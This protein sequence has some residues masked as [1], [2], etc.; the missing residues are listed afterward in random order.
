VGRAR[1]GVRRRW[2]CLAVAIASLALAPAA[3]AAL[4]FQSLAAAPA[5][6]AA[7]AHSNVGIHIGF[8]D[9]GADVKDLTV[10]LPPGLVGDPTATPLCTLDQLHSDSCPSA[11]QVGTVTTGVT[12]HVLG[13]LPVPLTVNGSLYNVVP[14][15]GEPA[16]FGIVLR[17]TGSDPLPLLQKIIQVS[18][19]QLR[20]SDFGLNT[21]LTNIPREAHA[22][23]QAL[24]IPIDITSIDIQLNGIVGGKGFM[25]NPT[26]CGTKTT[27]FTADSYANPNQKVTGQATFTS[28]NCASLP[29][30]PTFTADVGSRGHTQPVASPPV[31]TTILQD[32]GEAGLQNAQVLL[33]MI[34]NVDISPLS[35]PCSVAQFSSNASG[36]PV[37]SI[38]GSASATSPFLSGPEAGAV[39]IVAGARPAD[40][41]RLGVDLHGPLSLQLFGSFV[42]AQA[43]V[44]QVFKGLPDI[45]IS[46]FTLRFKA[47]GLLI[48]GGDLCKPPAPAFPVSFTGW[49]GAAQGRKVSATVHGCS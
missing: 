9:P 13:L 23:G 45:P 24:T 39:V 16:R 6:P 15:A 22:A 42:F 40:L 30:S 49:N 25:R 14:G 31:T 11:S 43:G 34:L 28:T 18:D 47:G 5:N 35:N 27:R 7:G 36:C 3:H 10:G 29:F 8:T 20:K 21:V 37:Q 19:V 17:P 33:P 1:G 12:A 38:V 46:R 26:S 4:G 44:G 32:D 41:P 48:N 2:L